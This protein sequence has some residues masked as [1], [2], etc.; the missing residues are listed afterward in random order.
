M[1][2]ALRWLKA[3]R[4]DRALRCPARI[5]VATLAAIVLAGSG[6]R[7]HAPS[8]KAPFGPVSGSMA[9]LLSTDRQF[10]QRSREVGA[11]AAFDQF[12]AE[13]VTFLPDG[14]LP[15]HGRR[16]IPELMQQPPGSVLTWEP[17]G[18]DVSWSGDLG[19]TWGVYESRQPAPGGRMEV[20]RGKYVTIWRRQPDNS[21]KIVLDIGN[22]NEP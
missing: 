21:W 17:S 7:S 11:A 22:S 15:A 13:N 20:R 14:Q 2:Y 1:E 9:T 4:T 12:S 8:P 16:V 18:A 19:Y 3:W 10:A 6:C 5:V